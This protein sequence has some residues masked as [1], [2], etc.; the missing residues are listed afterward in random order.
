MA[1]FN[2]YFATSR[3]NDVRIVNVIAFT[4]GPKVNRVKLENMLHESG[5]AFD[6][7]TSD[8]PFRYEK[9]A[10]E[11]YAFSEFVDELESRGI[12]VEVVF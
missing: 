10:H 3:T 5:F 9:K 4:V 12:S 2:G 8:K 6:L 1:K 7:I 11:I